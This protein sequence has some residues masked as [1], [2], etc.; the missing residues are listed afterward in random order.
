MPYDQALDLAILFH[1]VVYDEKPDKEVR[2]IDFM[3]D[4]FNDRNGEFYC[5]YS[6]DSI[7][8][9]AALIQTTI[10]H[11]PTDD[12]RL[13]LCDLADL[14]NDFFRELNSQN[15][16]MESVALYGIDNSQY[17]RNNIQFMRGLRNR[18]EDNMDNWQSCISEAQH[19]VNIIQGIGKQIRSSQE[20]LCKL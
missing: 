3:Y 19:F 18:L 1:D 17:Y 4:L 2:S 5:H 20:A 7:V 8:R 14:G 10:D 15:I 11:T 6:K 16:M 12:N 13:I 9:A